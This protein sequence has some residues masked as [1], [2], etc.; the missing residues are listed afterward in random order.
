VRA[1]AD[2]K[3]AREVCCGLVKQSGKFV[4]YASAKQAEAL[5]GITMKYNR[6]LGFGH[7]EVTQYSLP[8]G[9]GERAVVVV[10]KL[11]KTFD[12]YPR[13]YGKIKARPLG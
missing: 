11:W 12:G 10:K 9:A 1:L 13:S 6:S 5:K 3:I 8:E 7:E 4:Y 2:Y